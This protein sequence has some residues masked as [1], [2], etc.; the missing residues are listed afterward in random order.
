VHITPE[1][2]VLVVGDGKLGQLIAQSIALTGCRLLVIGRHRSKLD[3]LARRGIETAESVPQGRRFDV[4][5][6]CTGN[7]EGFSVARKSLRPRGTLVMKSTYAGDLTVNASSLV[8]DEIT[9]I[10][11]RCGPFAPALRLL[12][13][14]AVDVRPLIRATFPLA[15]G[16]AAFAEA[17][18]P[19]AL[20]V[21]IAA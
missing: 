13:S 15:G 4:A 6:D 14:R 18:K 21:L 19:G 8:V 1:D 11:S 12:E 2:R 20:K 10:G 9:L 3:L 17:Q 16:V 7:A 5:V